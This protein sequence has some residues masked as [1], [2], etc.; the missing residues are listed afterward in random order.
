MNEIELILKQRGFELT[1]THDFATNLIIDKCPLCRSKSTATITDRAFMCMSCTQEPLKI[2]ELFKKLDISYDTSPTDFTELLENDL[3]DMFDPQYSKGISTGYDNLDKR[4]GGLLQ[5][6]L[7]I[8]G[9]ET[10]MG[11]SVLASNLLVN[12]ITKEEKVCSYFDLEN[13]RMASYKRFI[14]IKGLISVDMF[15]DPNNITKV[16]DTGE[17]FKNKLIY[18]DHIK[19]DVFINESRGIKMA[20]AFGGLIRQDVEK[21]SR[22][23]VIDPLENFEGDDKEFNVIGRVVEYFKDLAQE[24]HISII[25]LHHLKKPANSYSNTVSNISEATPARYRIPTVHD[26]IGSSKITNKATDVWVM[27]RQKDDE[28]IQDKGRTLLRILKSR[29]D[30]P[31]ETGD[32]FFMM[33]LENLK[34]CEVS[35]L[36]PNTVEAAPHYRNYSN[37]DLSIGGDN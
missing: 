25:I 29:E 12:V 37:P 17:K 1:K 20:E 28:V 27:V 18:R 2:H 32:L 8:L 11:K 16:V 23:V 22:V 5:G 21:G 36:D 30:R 15:Q 13:G 9:A 4:T 19:L 6:H 14:A 26:F 7:Y 31:N 24:L 33:N 10:G 3:E 35:T 34:I